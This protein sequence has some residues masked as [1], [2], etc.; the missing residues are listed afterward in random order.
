MDRETVKLIT[1]SPCYEFFILLR[2]CQAAPPFNPS[3]MVSFCKHLAR[4]LIKIC[5][6][7]IK[8]NGMAMLEEHPASM[9]GD[10]IN[11]GQECS[12]PPAS[13]CFSVP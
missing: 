3:M 13:H 11:A 4:D 12:M 5:N 10:V 2:S 7:M 6:D 9:E 8:A 1:E